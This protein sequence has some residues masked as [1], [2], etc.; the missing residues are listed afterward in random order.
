MIDIHP[1]HHGSMTRRDIL[2][3]LAIV[4]LGIVRELGE[5]DVDELSQHEAG[6]HQS[7]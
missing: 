5:W 6:L 3:H 4:V 1:P 7:V 2:T